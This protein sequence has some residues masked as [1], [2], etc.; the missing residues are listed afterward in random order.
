MIKK[1]PITYK[2]FSE[3]G[4]YSPEGLKALSPKLTTLEPFQ[5]SMEEQL[6][7]AHCRG[8]KL[9]VQGVQPKLSAKLNIVKHQFELTDVGGTFIIKPQH[10]FYQELPENEDLSMR[11]AQNLVDVPLH[12]LIYNKDLKMSYFIKRFD[13][14]S[15]KKKFPCEDFSQLGLYFRS[16]KY[17][18]SI[19]KIIKIIEKY[20][21]YPQIEKQ[22]IFARLLF[23]FLIGN[24]DMH[25]KNYSLITK[26]DLVI[27]SPGYDF[28]NTTLVLGA[29]VKEQL[30]L[31]L[32][33]KKNNLTKKDLIRYLGMECLQLPEKIIK[34]TLELIYAQKSLWTHLITQSFLSPLSKEKYSSIVD[35]R[36]NLL[37]A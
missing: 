37:F 20:C 17:N 23:N 24:E 9:S 29:K 21:T 22:K 1:C 33:D 4:L 12:G 15:S 3:D 13:R 10:H 27:L 14:L 16:D 11:L 25:L 31:P 30:A 2:N 32:N 7:E 8:G 19:E 5:Y 6:E 34:Q 36:L 28:V 35:N 18:S 26:N